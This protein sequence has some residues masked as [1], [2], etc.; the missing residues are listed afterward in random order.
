MR[1]GTEQLVV[2]DAGCFQVMRGESN[3]VDT[4]NLRHGLSPAMLNET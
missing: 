1:P 2:E 4:E 3:V